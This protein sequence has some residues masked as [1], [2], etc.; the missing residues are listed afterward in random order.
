MNAEE[1]TKLVANLGRPGEPEEEAAALQRLIGMARK[2]NHNPHLP[3][4]VMYTLRCA[5]ADLEGLLQEAQYEPEDHPG[6]QTLFQIKECITEADPMGPEAADQGLAREIAGTEVEQEAVICI[7]LKDGNV[8]A[9]YGSRD[10][11]V[12][13]LDYDNPEMFKET[14]LIE[15][16]SEEGVQCFPSVWS[17]DI[18]PESVQKTIEALH[19]HGL[20][21]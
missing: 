19:G 15:V 3:N 16:Y 21:D 1:F 5:Q 2:V 8:Q 20:W 6:Y 9:V 4:K 17:V 14:E 13:V 7:E 18:A 12:V 10:I 11:P